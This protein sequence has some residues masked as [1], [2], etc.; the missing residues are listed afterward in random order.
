MIN[1]AA[2]L[3]N[4]TPDIIF[5][6]KMSA[7]MFLRINNG[8]KGGCTVFELVSFEKT[9]DSAYNKKIQTYFK[10]TFLCAKKFQTDSQSRFGMSISRSKNPI[11]V[12]NEH[13]GK[14]ENSKHLHSIGKKR[15]NVESV[16]LSKRDNKKLSISIM[17]D[18]SPPRSNE[19][20]KAKPRLQVCIPNDAEERQHQHHHQK[21]QV[22]SKRLLKAVHVSDN[23]QLEFEP[24]KK[25]K[26]NNNS[27]IV[28]SDHEITTKRN[29]P[30]NKDQISDDHNKN[31]NNNNNNKNNNNN[32]ITTIT[33]IITI[34]II[35]ITIT[36]IITSQVFLF[37]ND[38]LMNDKC[39]SIALDAN[40]QS[41]EIVLENEQVAMDLRMKYH[42]KVC[43]GKIVRMTVIHAPSEAVSQPHPHSPS[44]SPSQINA[45]SAVTTKKKNDEDTQAQQKTLA[46][47]I[48][49][50]S[51]SPLKP[52]KSASMIMLIPVKSAI[53]GLGFN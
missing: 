9:N 31:N 38:E 15:S 28:V 50:R 35:T 30:N 14:N 20:S 4:N 37:D 13:L 46:K 40:S 16:S 27:V 52:H 44:H 10:R 51:R 49:T 34:I 47:T 22:H 48:L 23:K 26:L 17:N 18:V 43:Q 36:I 24:S 5:Y 39:V 7:R 1:S 19:T 3:K 41:A 21:E 32:N 8:E 25:R 53:A 29:V 42:N 11:S 33:T 45:H 12:I 6:A 2:L